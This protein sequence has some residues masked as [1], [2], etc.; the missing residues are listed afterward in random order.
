MYLVAEKDSVEAGCMGV[1][2]VEGLYAKAG[3]VA[4]SRR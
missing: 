3:A 1:S 4:G 2:L